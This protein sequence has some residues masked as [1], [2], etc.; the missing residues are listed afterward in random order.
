MQV[1]AESVS[2]TVSEEDK[3][4]CEVTE[5]SHNLVCF[6]DL[7]THTSPIMVMR[8]AIECATTLQMNH[9]TKGPEI[10]REVVWVN[11]PHQDHNPYG[12]IGYFQL[13]IYSLEP[14]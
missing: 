6:V 3:S 10:G 13:K 1:L 9:L 4:R 5:G 12:D 8:A 2:D 7:C 14:Q 11:E